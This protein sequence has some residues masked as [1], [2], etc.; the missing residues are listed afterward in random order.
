MFKSIKNIQATVAE[1][2]SDVEDIDAEKISGAQ[3]AQFALAL[4]KSMK[5]FLNRLQA[6]EEYLGL[7]FKDTNVEQRTTRFHYKKAKKSK[8]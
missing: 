3:L 5:P 8:K 2:Q 6:M 1:L 4:V 7:E